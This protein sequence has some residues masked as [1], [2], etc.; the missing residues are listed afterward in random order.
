MINPLTLWGWGVGLNLDWSATQL[1][2]LYSFYFVLVGIAFLIVTLS[3][4][5]NGHFASSM[6]YV[7]IFSTIIL[8][9]IL[10]LIHLGVAAILI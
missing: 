6:I 3:Y 9:L 2:T 1:F 8:S 10:F 5:F 7:G 4:I